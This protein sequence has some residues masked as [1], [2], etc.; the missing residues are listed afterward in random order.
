MED[1]YNISNYPIIENLDLKFLVLFSFFLGIHDIPQFYYILKNKKTE[2][3]SVF[4]YLFKC[5]FLLFL[6]SYA[7]YL[8]ENY[9]IIGTTTCFFQTFMIT[10][11]IFHYSFEEKNKLSN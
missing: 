7:F 10:L 2:D 8:N 9:L 6:D 3:L 1:I 5:L 11:L 4:S